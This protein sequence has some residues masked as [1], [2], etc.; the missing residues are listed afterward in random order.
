MA[1][2]DSRSLTTLVALLSV[3]FVV[4]IVHYVDN[5][6]NYD[7][8]PVLP[9]ESSLP[10]PSV[11][12]VAGAWFV[13]TAF[14]LLGLWLFVRNRMAAAAVALAVYSGS[15]LV[16]VAHY[17]VPNATD[18][19]WWRQAHVITDIVL[20]ALVFAYAI[21]LATLPRQEDPGAEAPRPS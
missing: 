19:V 3:A 13:F 10:N 4:S 21:R 6:L 8:F 14:G 20:G 5:V 18:M 15:G 11:D 16:G 17:L 12:V 7:D 1:R 2:A 9:T